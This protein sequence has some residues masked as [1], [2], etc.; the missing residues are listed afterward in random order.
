MN[1]EPIISQDQETDSRKCRGAGASLA[2]SIAFDGR[3]IRQRSRRAKQSCVGRMLSQ[4]ASREAVRLLYDNL[5]L[6]RTA[7]KETRESAKEARRLPAFL[8][9]SGTERPRVAA[10]ARAYLDSVEGRFSEDTCVAFLDG[11]QETAIL[12]MDE[13]WALKPAIQSE[14]LERMIASSTSW[15]VLLNSLRQVGESAWKELFETA[16]HIDRVLREDPAGAYALMDFDSRERYRGVIGR[17]ARHSRRSEH[18]VAET[19]LRLA[20]EAS[21]AGDGTR[22]ALRR[23]HI[24]YYLVDR[25]LAPLQGA[26]EYRA[27]LREKIQRAALGSPTAYYLIAIELCTY[28]IVALMLAGVDSLTP[29]FAGLVLL[30]LPATQAAVAFVNSLATLL[31]S[32]RTLPRLDF[33]K[34]VPEECATIVAVP[35][36]LLNEEQVRDLALDLEIRFLANRDRQIYF[37]LLTDCPDAGAPFDERDRLVDL[38]RGLIEGLNRRYPGS[39]FLMLHRHRVY[40]EKEG[41]WMGWERKRGKLLDFNRFL[42]GGFDSF[43]VKAGDLSVLPRIRYVI[44]LDADTQLP[45]DSAARLIGTLAHPLNAAVMDEE[46][47]IVVEGYGILQPRIGISIRSAAR[48]RLAAVYSGETGFDI[49]TRAVS[50]VYQDLFGEGIFTGKGIYEVDVLRAVLEHRFPENALLSHDLIE[51]AYAR[52]GLVSDIELIDDYPSHFSAY[53]RRKHRWVRGDWQTLRWLAERVPDRTLHLAPNPISLISRW[54]ILD[55]LRRSLQEPSLVVL[56]LGAW[57]FLPGRADYWTAAA[58]AMPFL[59]AYWGLVFSILHPPRSAQAMRAWAGNTFQQFEE[60]T[61]SALLTLVFLLHQ[62]FLSVDAIVRSILRMFVTG[63]KL[64]EWETAAEAGSAGRSRNAVDIYLKWMPL[65]SAIVALLV[66]RIRPAALQ[67][68]GPILVLWAS[69][70]AVSAWLN[71]PVRSSS[72][73]LGGK[74][75]DWL[76]GYGDKM[77]R[78]FQDWSSPATNWL[79]PDQVRENGE[80]VTTLSPTN[81]GLLLNARIAAVHFGSSTLAQFAS[82][83]CETLES[84]AALPKYRGHLLNWYDIDT[85]QPAGTRFVSTVD[86]GNLAACLWTLKQAALAFGSEAA[87]SKARTPQT[88][89]RL[90]HIAGV[91]DRMVREMDF[92]FLYDARRKVLSVG[93]DM[94]A[95]RTTPSYYDLLASE[96]RIATFV[97]IAKGD[98]PQEAWFHLSRAHTR[99]A[100][101]SVL[102]SWTGTMFEY[103]MPAIWM[104]HYPGTL[105]YQSVRAVVKAQKE[106]ARRKGVPWG[107]SESAFLAPDGGTG[108]AAFGIPELA[109][110]R[111]DS[112][113]LVISPYSAFLAAPVDAPGVL[114][115]LK[116]MEEYGWSGRYGFYEAIDYSHGGG[117]P[118]RSW[119]AHHQ[120]MSLLAA[121]NLLFDRPLQRYFH[122]EP[123]VMATELLLHERVPAG[124]QADEAEPVAGPAPEPLPAAA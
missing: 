121:C 28:V 26:V 52:A 78:F 54:K 57:L 10:I 82:E 27:P 3:H 73:A 23:A 117:D 106:Y 8:D 64:L 88:A 69:S 103:L 17:L 48:S 99:F 107:I 92:R 79:I 49:Y 104:Q 19:A 61:A 6:I 102:L 111:S 37:A 96:S 68:A 114:K 119:M 63:R 21:A 75:A 5:R 47:R 122:A 15:P 118:I 33:S 115:N 86:S 123:Y 13:I 1:Q 53:S 22:A 101:E 20:R 38:C 35:T 12:E 29:F 124:L 32:P 83:T 109:L 74:D 108:Y 11:F 7:E 95:G 113:A 51:G 85:L 89:E 120:G 84:V 110:K 87:W 77:C 31:I 44:T 55:N 60:A 40:N 105:T 18:G 93:Y 43:P 91:C 14:I 59:A 70:W 90:L 4:P 45:R 25:G 46:Q 39:G 36:L 50:D 67:A 116:Q 112:A 34:G 58:A 81:L 80:P 2:R 71:R 24:G 30:I 76:R 16:N 56:L 98:I 62:A 65:L 97:A 66:W 72:R 9:D 41:R 42:R 94:A 100:G